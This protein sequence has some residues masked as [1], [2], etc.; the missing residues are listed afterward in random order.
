MKTNEQGEE[1]EEEGKNNTKCNANADSDSADNEPTMKTPI[2]LWLIHF[3]SY[4]KWN[5]R[6]P[7][8]SSYN[9]NINANT[10]NEFMKY[11]QRLFV[12]N[13]LTQRHNGIGIRGENIAAAASRVYAS[14]FHYTATE[15]N[16]YWCV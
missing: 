7:P 4:S 5:S 11:T 1:E 8:N 3:I 12:P 16:V 15:L 10:K 9:N 13:R 6:A 2:L 14:H